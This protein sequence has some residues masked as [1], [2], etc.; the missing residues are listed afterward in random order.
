M[1]PLDGL[2][3]FT[4]ESYDSLK[5][6]YENYLSEIHDLNLTNLTIW[7]HKHR[8][9]YIEIKGYVWY[10]YHSTESSEI[11]FSEPVGDYSNT[12]ALLES[13]KAWIHYAHTHHFP[14]KLRHIGTFF[15]NFLENNGF[16]IESEAIEADFDYLYESQN[17]AQLSGNRYHKK[18]NHVNQFKKNYAHAMKSESITPVNAL[19]A[20]KAA[21]NWCIAN[22]CKDSMDLCHEFNGIKELFTQW[23]LFSRRGV[24]GIVLTIDEKPISFSIGEPLNKTTYLVHIEK[25]DSDYQGA[26]A[27]INQSMAESASTQYEFLNREQDMG[28]EGIRKAKQSYH[29]HHLVEKYD[30]TLQMPL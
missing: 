10:Q 30:V 26:Y 4:I 29:P 27:M 28:I 21:K 19:E 8:L 25:A 1:N 16:I 6:Y 23:D 24:E 17:L 20:L 15:Q 13:T 7:R 18:K 22:G 2:K 9:H 14:L 12:Q 5:P 3:P 11:S